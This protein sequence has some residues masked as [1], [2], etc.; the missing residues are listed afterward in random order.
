MTASIL[1]VHGYGH[2]KACFPDCFSGFVFPH[3]MTDV[4]KQKGKS[5]PL[6]SV[7]VLKYHLVAGANWK[8][9]SNI[10]LQGMTLGVEG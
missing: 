10:R 3:H 4:F 7:K 6:E 1:T 9:G 5:R 8:A 2:R